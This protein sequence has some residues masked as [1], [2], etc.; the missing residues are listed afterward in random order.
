MTYTV[1]LNCDM[2]EGF[3]AYEMGNDL[4]ILDYVT[5]ANIA[6]GFHAGDPSRM[7]KTVEAALEKGVAVGAHPGLPDLQG[8][9]RRAMALAPREAYDIVV[10]QVG[11]LA[12]FATALGGRL[13][14]VKAHGALYN[15][16]A[17]DY[18]LS[19]AIA[20][21]VVDVDSQLVLVGLAGSEMLRAAREVG[22]VA[23]GEVFADR[24][25][26]EDGSLTPRRQADA[27]IESGEQ[28][29]AQ[30]TRMIKE[31]FVR[32]TNGRDV[33]V[34]ADTLCIHG[35]RPGALAFVRHVRAYLEHEGITVARLRVGTETQ[36]QHL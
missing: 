28:G 29:A 8:F 26:Q 1:D 30:A 18:A 11:A 31:G 9:G 20:Q 16:A 32:A 35:D 12:A 3:G 36:E 10:Y 21:A 34:R 25:Y 33:P 23:A 19:K 6:C 14:H 2:G 7:H 13:A 5:S 4:E 15:Q 17:K 22:L 27:M 24:T